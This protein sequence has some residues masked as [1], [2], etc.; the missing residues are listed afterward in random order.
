MNFLQ[1]LSLMQR[2]S[3]LLVT[4]FVVITAAFL[5]IFSKVS[6]FEQSK[7]IPAIEEE[8]I[9][10]TYVVSTIF[11][12]S[13]HV[14]ENT[15]RYNIENS[16]SVEDFS[17]L[18]TDIMTDASLYDLMHH[19]D[20]E[21][22]IAYE[23]TGNASLLSVQFTGSDKQALP[24]VQKQFESLFLA[25][26]RAE[27][28]W[29]VLYKTL[30]PTPYIPD[31]ETPVVAALPQIDVLSTS[32]IAIL[33]ILIG[34]FGALAII[35]AAEA[36]DQR[37]RSVQQLKGATE[38]PVLSAISSTHQ[39]TQLLQLLKELPEDVPTTLIGLSDERDTQHMA[40]VL[41]QVATG[42]S[43]PAAIINLTGTTVD[44]THP[45]LTVINKTQISAVDC[46]SNDFRKLIANLQKSNHRVL[47][48]A[49]SVEESAIGDALADISQ[50]VL[51]VRFGKDRITAVKQTQRLL[52]NSLN[53][54]KGYV[55]TG[56]NTKH[57]YAWGHK[58]YGI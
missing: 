54:V 1:M 13:A 18:A 48:A 31:E 53:A 35:M 42:E 50:L 43:A 51:L 2:R 38:L 32:D 24:D 8:Q 3:I 10:D 45:N 37:I 27:D 44:F 57:E 7:L 17:L 39:Q 6:E 46:L 4:S 14:A 55:I 28:G 40:T 11:F 41:G 29:S 33:S 52:G 22:P 5:G 23:V 34:V 56:Y 26:L 19:E 49:P 9:T 20:L 15:D 47:I 21:S 25:S 58:A 12:N 16:F 36:I 30:Q